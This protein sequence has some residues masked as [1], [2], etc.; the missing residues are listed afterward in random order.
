MSLA[1]GVQPCAPPAASRALACTCLWCTCGRLSPRNSM[2]SSSSL[3]GSPAIV[4]VTMGVCATVLRGTG[5]RVHALAVIS[6]LL[7][8]TMGAGGN[9]LVA[10]ELLASCQPSYST[11]QGSVGSEYPTDPGLCQQKARWVAGRSSLALHYTCTST[12]GRCAA[13]VQEGSQM[14]SARTCTRKLDT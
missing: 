13:P 2:S 8:A 9:G 12:C 7:G 3:F 5:V 10:P 4:A 1:C 11:R 6:L 14:R